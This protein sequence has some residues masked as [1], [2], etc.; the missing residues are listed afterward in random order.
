MA[1]KVFAAA[2]ATAIIVSTAPAA[3]QAPETIPAAELQWRNMFPG[4]D[5]AP[6]YGDWEKEAHGN[7]VRFA[8]GTKVPIHTH[9]NDYHAVMVSGQMANLFEGDQ[10]VVIDPGTYFYMAPTRP[11]GHEC[12]SQDP[13]FF[14]VHGDALWDLELIEE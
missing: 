2:A 12:V 10:R 8:P 6:A 11:H 4:V 3:A 14:Y 7:F 1:R 13:C 5:F 9:T